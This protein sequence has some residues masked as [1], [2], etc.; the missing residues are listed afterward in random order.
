MIGALIATQRLVFLLILIVWLVA[1]AVN[2]T[3]MSRHAF[4][5]DGAGVWRPVYGRPRRLLPWSEIA[6]VQRPNRYDTV[7]VLLLKD[8]TSLPLL[9]I[10]ASESGR[11]AAIGQLAAAAQLA[12]GKL[13]APRIGVTAPATD[14]ATATDQQP[15][16]TPPA[17]S[18]TEAHD[19]PETPKPSRISASAGRRHFGRPA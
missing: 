12:P 6:A 16:A 11:V 7:A 15:A 14:P 17:P 2:V 8:G 19:T 13:S 10:D 4:R 5:V 3:T 9:G 18:I 1:F